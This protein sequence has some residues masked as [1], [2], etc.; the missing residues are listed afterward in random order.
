VLQWPPAL[1]ARVDKVTLA[2]PL[3][4][5]DLHLSAAHPRTLARFERFVAEE[6][7]QHAELVILGDLFEYWVGDDATDDAVGNRVADALAR[8]SAAGVKLYL[9]HGNR[10]LLLGGRFAKRVGGTLLADPALARI[11]G[12]TVTLTHG[13]LYC[14]LDVDYQRFRR[15]ARNP[16]FQLL[17]LSRSLARRRAYIGEARAVSEASKK[18]KNVEIMDV[19]PAAIDDALRTARVTRMIHGHPHRPATHRFTLDGAAAERWVLPDWDFDA[20]KVRGGYLQVGEGDW[21]QVDLAA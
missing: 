16:L 4:I 1:A 17:F 2:D 15:R 11:G 7:R 3:F 10:D 9:M 21:R 18:Q 13:D 5:S 6:A 12:R 14:T 8:L 19:T 20:A